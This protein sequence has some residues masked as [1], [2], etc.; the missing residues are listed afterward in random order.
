MAYANELWGGPSETYKY[1][2]DS[3]TDWGQQLKGTKKYLDQRGVKNCWFAYF[4]EPAIQFSS[5]GIPCKPLPTPDTNWFGEEI[6]TPPTIEGPVL[7]S[8]G[9]LSGYELGS[10]VLN[11]YRDFQSLRP[12]AVIE[13]GVFVFDGTFHV[14]LAS[15]LGHVQRA[16]RLRNHGQF[17]EALVEAQTAEALAPNAIQPQMVLGNVLT[18][19]NRGGEACSAYEKALAIAK[20]MDPGA[21]ED[22]I[23]NIE[24]QLAG[25]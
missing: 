25:K 24:Q 10:N 9:T 18:A 21:R 4:V 8:A 5:Y 15:A 20:T 17:D 14:P 19:M 7:I 3:N 16:L 22:W 12:T 2:T 13:Y 6:D 23:R 1:L 11:P